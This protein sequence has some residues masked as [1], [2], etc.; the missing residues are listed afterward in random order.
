MSNEI[1]L[2]MAG[3]K[4]SSSQIRQARGTRT[5][6][7]NIVRLIESLPSAY[8]PEYRV[9]D[10]LGGEQV[11][12][13]TADAKIAFCVAFGHN[14]KFEKSEYGDGGLSIIICERCGIDARTSH[15]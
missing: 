7:A 5:Q 6:I 11:L 15:S 10:A 2:F 13:I 4:T 3:L 1:E 12:V 14:W 8:Q 9:M